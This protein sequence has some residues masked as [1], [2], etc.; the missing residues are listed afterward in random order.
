ML[1]KSLHCSTDQPITL[2]LAALD[3]SQPV[4]Q[5]AA[6]GVN[7]DDVIDDVTTSASGEKVI[8][9]VVRTVRRI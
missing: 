5:H 3:V 1:L 8:M 2:P 7:D 6:S 9:S 4:A